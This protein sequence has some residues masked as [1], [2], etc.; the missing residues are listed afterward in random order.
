MLVEAVH[1]NGLGTVHP[2][3]RADPQALERQVHCARQVLLYIDCLGQDVDND[4]PAPGEKQGR[5]DVD[6]PHAPAQSCGDAAVLLHQFVHDAVVPAAEVGQTTNLS[7]LLPTRSYS[8]RAAETPSHHGHTTAPSFS[9]R[10]SAPCAVLETLDDLG[11]TIFEREQAAGNAAMDRPS[12]SAE[13][14]CCNS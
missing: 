8:L 14:S 5:I 1:D 11:R 2:V 3:D 13:V 10:V 7:T 12:E 4:R 6:A 9:P